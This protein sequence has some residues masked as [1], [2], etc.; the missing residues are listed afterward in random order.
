LLERVKAALSA[1][2]RTL[3]A[4]I[5][6]TA[7][8]LPGGGLCA[9]YAPLVTAP[10]NSY[11]YSRRSTPFSFFGRHRDQFYSRKLQEGTD[12]G[13]AGALIRALFARVASEPLLHQLLYVDLHTWLPDDLLVKADKMTMAN[14][15]EL[16]VPFLD[17]KLLEFAASLTPEYKVHGQQGTRVLKEAFTRQIPGVIL[18][19]K[20]VGFPVP[21]K[22]WLR[23]DLRAFVHDTLLSE[24][25]LG[26]GYFARAEVRRLVHRC[27][28]GEA[29]SEQ[30]FSLIA[31]ELWHRRFAD[32]SPAT[33]TEAPP[34]P[35]LT[36]KS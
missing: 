10:L 17:H 27:F 24:R 20:K 7:G 5:L 32:V 22:R 26:R 19:R 12:A 15:L 21:L 29:V 33:A 18:R 23:T 9:R 8:R 30:V 36:W 28:S 25:S 35:T 3:L 14:S 34:V 31:L 13:E 6:E 16:R 2:Q 4:R 11:Y 1:K